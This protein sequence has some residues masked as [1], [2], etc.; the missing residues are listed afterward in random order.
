MPDRRNTG[1]AY[2]LY[3]IPSTTA[4]TDAESTRA[5]QRVFKAVLNVSPYRQPARGSLRHASARNHLG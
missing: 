3:K 5:P 2:H 1:N 4:Y